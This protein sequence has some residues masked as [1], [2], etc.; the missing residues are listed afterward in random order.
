MRLVFLK[1]ILPRSL[2][3]CQQ[4]KK[5]ELEVL[6]EE[7]E[8]ARM[9]QSI[10]HAFLYPRAILALG[11][12]SWLHRAFS[13]VL[14][15]SWHIGHYEVTSVTGMLPMTPG[16]AAGGTAPRAVPPPRPAN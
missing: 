7:M 9:W 1:T 12:R 11:Y 6:V 10:N 8:V 15:L 3:G 16:R 13:P 4:A 14:S 2:S 5:V